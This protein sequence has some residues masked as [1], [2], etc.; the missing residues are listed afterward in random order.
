MEKTTKNEVVFFSEIC[1]LCVC[2]FDVELRVPI[3]C[4]QRAKGSYAEM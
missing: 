1:C 2:V 4:V 3:R